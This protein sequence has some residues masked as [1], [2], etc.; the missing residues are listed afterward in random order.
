MRKLATEI[1]ALPKKRFLF[2]WKKPI[3]PTRCDMRD[4]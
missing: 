1:T 3:T 4:W 2:L